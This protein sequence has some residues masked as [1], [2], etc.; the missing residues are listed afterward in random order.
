MSKALYTGKFGP[1]G[2][3]SL[4]IVNRLSS[5]ASQTVKG[6]QWVTSN[7]IT[8]FL[9]EVLLSYRLLFG[10]SKAGRQHFRRTVSAQVFEDIPRQGQD[11]LLALMCGRKSID[12]SGQ[13]KERQNYRLARDFAMLRCRIAVLQQQL[14][15]SKP[16]GW[17]ELWRD[18]RDSAQWV[19]FWAVIIIGG[20]GLLLSLMQVILAIMQITL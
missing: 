2:T 20:L 10:Q 14:A 18:K 17:K 1:Y 6:Q 7:E 13:G 15:T 9:R 12:F 19:T 3:N 16:R 11:P 4:D 5:C 8:E